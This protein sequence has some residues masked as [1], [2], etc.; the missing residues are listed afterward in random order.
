LESR[1]FPGKEGRTSLFQL[2]LK[3]S[4]YAVIGVSAAA[5]LLSIWVFLHYKVPV[6]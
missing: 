6:F 1:G 3:A 2:Q 5:I 4:D